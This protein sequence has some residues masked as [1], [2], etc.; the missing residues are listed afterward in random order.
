MRTINIKQLTTLILASLL[1]TY[2]SA[3]SGQDTSLEKQICDGYMNTPYLF[4]GKLDSVKYFTVKTGENTFANYVSYLVEVDKVIKGN[5]QP[6]TIE[7]VYYAEGITYK[8]TDHIS[9]TKFSEPAETAPSK[10]LYL[11]LD[12]IGHSVPSYYKN[13]NNKTLFFHG[14]VSIAN[15]GTINKD[16]RILDLGNYFPNIADFYTYIKANYGIDV[17]TK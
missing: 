6:G 14:G 9:S 1:C 17:S 5:I 12:S 13:S 16:P 11:G 7:L 4:Q 8:G 15:D 10:G 2:I 3:Q